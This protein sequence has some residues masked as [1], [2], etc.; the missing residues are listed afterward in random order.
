MQQGTLRLGLLL[1]LLLNLLHSPAN[2]AGQSPVWGYQMHL[3]DGEYKI[4]ANAGAA[5]G[6]GCASIINGS[7]GTVD[8]VSQSGITLIVS[9]RYDDVNGDPSFGG[10]IP[11][12]WGAACPP[13]TIN[14][15]ERC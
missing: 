6:Y 9:C 11:S 13:G 14:T 5:A 3:G 2:Y 1:S 4:F 7:N 10:G 12:V 8:S 15:G